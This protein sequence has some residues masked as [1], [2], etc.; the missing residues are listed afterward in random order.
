MLEKRQYLAIEKLMEGMPVTEIAKVVGVHRSTIYNWLENE[1]FKKELDTLRLEIQTS[2]K[3]HVF[4]NI[5]LYIDELQSLA[6]DKTTSQKV[7]VDALKYLVNRVWGNTT[8][9]AEVT[10]N[11]ETGEKEINLKELSKE[12]EEL[13]GDDV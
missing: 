9:K 2:T 10:V 8:T 4:N 3:E 11:K 7:R 6:L 5:R 12:L 13:E 1:E